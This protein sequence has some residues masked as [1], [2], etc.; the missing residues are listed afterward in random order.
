[1]TKLKNTKLIGV[2]DDFNYIF[3]NEGVVKVSSLSNDLKGQNVIPY[4][5]ENL[6][7]AIDILKENYLY[8]YKTNK[9]SLQEYLGKSRKFLYTIVETLK[10]NNSFSIITEWESRFGNKLVLI[11]ES[12]DKL[13]IEERVNQ[14]FDFFKKV[15]LEFDPIG[16]V[17]SG[18]QNA[19]SFAGKTL[20]SVG[21][22]TVDQAK[23]IK[24]KGLATYAKEAGISIWNVVSNQIASAWKCVKSG[25]ECT[26]EGIRK[27]LFSVGA[28]VALSAVST[29]PVVGQVT[30]G[31]LYG[32]MLIWDLYKMMS[33][34]YE[35]GPYQWSIFDI[36]FDIIGAI[37]PYAARIGKTAFAGIKSFAQFGK[38]AAAKGGIWGSLY[39]AII[40]GVGKLQNLIGQ[41]A[42]FLG[43]KLGIK[44]LAQWGSKASQKV[45]ELA[46]EMAAGA[47]GSQVATQSGQAAKSLTK[48][49]TQT[50][51]LEFDKLVSNWKTQQANL[52]KS[53]DLRTMTK[54]TKNQLVQQAKQNANPSLKQQVKQIWTKGPK[55]PMPTNGQLIKTA[56]G[57]F[58]FSLG[59]CAVLGVPNAEECLG[60]IKND[61]ISQEEYADAEIDY[62]NQLAQG[63]EDIEIQGEL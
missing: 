51:K 13:V 33:G 60:R 50:E 25:V 5:F 61:L 53:A 4:T 49:L 38:M 12:V 35:S 6:D 8:N 30:N 16:M 44:S 59:A 37:F 56:R 18:A 47:K 32:T 62:Q 1:M 26:M 3:T 34:K 55:T 52:G 7:V 9:L 24:E 58:V 17:K 2:S 54:E 28:T 43:E 22:W 41:G 20:K 21:D 42:K 39:K 14:S 46:D 57:S 10:P 40:N 19:L 36:I 63:I 15:L 45:K 23:Q 29:I 48:S 31:V 27:L 11:N